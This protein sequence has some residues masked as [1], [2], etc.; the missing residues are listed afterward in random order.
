MSHL[1]QRRYRRFNRRPMGK[2]V[3]TVVVKETS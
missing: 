1:W 2:V 3:V